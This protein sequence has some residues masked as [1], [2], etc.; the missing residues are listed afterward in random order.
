[1]SIEY[2]IKN[3]DEIINIY[4]KMDEIDEFE[5]IKD[6]ISIKISLD[7]NNNDKKYIKNAN[8]YI[9][10]KNCPICYNYIEHKNTKNLSCKHTFCIK[11]YQRIH[12][13]TQRKA[14]SIQTLIR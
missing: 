14:Q 3:V 4:K 10:C 6:D 5:E 13:Y 12:I 1:M 11:T 7:I 2:K 9:K 8:F